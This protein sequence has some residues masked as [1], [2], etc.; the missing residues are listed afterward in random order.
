[1][2]SHHGEDFGDDLLVAKERDLEPLLE[3]STELFDLDYDQMIAMEDWLTLAWCSGIRSGH[4]QLEAK[5]TQTDPDLG[6]V[7]ARQFESDFKPLMLKS[8]DSL[9]LTMPATISMW[10]F[11]REAWMAGNRTSTHELMRLYIEVNS[12]VPEEARQWLEEQKKGE[13]GETS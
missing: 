8:A 13:T 6:A 4:A 11:L 9:N 3:E 2:S 7:A 10:S 5:A 12:D 1:M